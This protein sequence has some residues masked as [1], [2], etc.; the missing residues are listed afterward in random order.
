MSGLNLRS[1]SALQERIKRPLVNSQGRAAATGS[2]LFH[3]PALRLERAGEVVVSCP[4][5]C[6]LHSYSNSY[7]QRPPDRT[8]ARVHPRITQNKNRRAP[9][10]QCLAGSPVVSRER[11]VIFLRHGWQLHQYEYE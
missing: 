9:S 8:T 1:V 3:C 4:V 11:I 5:R 7:H 6:V 2:L 10:F